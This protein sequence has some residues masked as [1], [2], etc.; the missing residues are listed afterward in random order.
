VTAIGRAW[1]LS[2][3]P[4]GELD[5]RDAEKRADVALANRAAAVTR[6]GDAQL[7]TASPHRALFVLQPEPAVEAAMPAAAAAGE[8]Q[9]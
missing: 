4:R 5:A 7:A 3:A 1:R 2:A 8:P 6:S 9:Q